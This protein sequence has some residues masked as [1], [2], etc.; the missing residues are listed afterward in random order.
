MVRIENVTPAQLAAGALYDVRALM[1]EQCISTN[2]AAAG[3]N[4]QLMTMG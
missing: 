4:A 3:G 2:T 1:H